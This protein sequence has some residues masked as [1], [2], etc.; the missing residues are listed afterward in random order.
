MKKQGHSLEKI[1]M[2]HISEKGDI[3]GMYNEPL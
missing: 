1:F 2:V 3:S